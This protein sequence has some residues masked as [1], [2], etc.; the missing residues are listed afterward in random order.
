MVGR[1]RAGV[2]VFYV[3]RVLTEVGGEVLVGTE[4][5]WKEVGDP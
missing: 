1:R 4:K 5:S 3:T 2:V